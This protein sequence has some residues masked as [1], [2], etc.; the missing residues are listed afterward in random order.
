MKGTVLFLFLY[1]LLTCII[2]AHIGEDNLSTICK[3]R[4]HFH[5]ISK[6]FSDLDTLSDYTSTRIDRD[7]SFSLRYDRYRIEWESEHL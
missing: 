5:R 4:E 1:I 6:G 2:V 7:L 3:W